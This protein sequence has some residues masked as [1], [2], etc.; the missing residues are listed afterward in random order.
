LEELEHHL[1]GQRLS[2]A[3]NQYESEVESLVAALTLKMVMTCSSET[4]VYIPG[5]RIHHNLRSYRNEM[6][7]NAQHAAV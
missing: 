2:Q 5:D 1:Q 7:D 4:S 3:R 6:M